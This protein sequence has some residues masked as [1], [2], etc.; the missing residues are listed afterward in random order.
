MRLAWD[1]GAPEGWWAFDTAMGELAQF[2]VG[3]PNHTC[4][5]V[6][7]VGFTVQLVTSR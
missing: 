2:H 5:V 6:G 1:A 3:E 4:G 7:S